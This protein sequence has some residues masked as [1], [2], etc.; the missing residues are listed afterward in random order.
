MISIC[1]YNKKVS[2]RLFTKNKYSKAKK[3]NIYFKKLIFRL[4]P[5]NFVRFKA[6]F[7][8]TILKVSSV[9]SSQS[10]LDMVNKSRLELNKGS[11]CA[12]ENLFQ[13]QI[14]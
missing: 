12:F 10:L 5:S 8:K 4:N 6:E 1:I 3:L 13:G 7:L 11:L 9:I 14:S 2:E